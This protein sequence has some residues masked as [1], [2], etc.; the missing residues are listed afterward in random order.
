MKIYGDY[1]T[2][3]QIFIELILKENLSDGDA[4]KEALKPY[5]F[6]E[7]V[8]AENG[9][10]TTP[11]LLYVSMHPWKFSFCVEGGNA[12]L[13]QGTEQEAHLFFSAQYPIGS[14]FV[15]SKEKGHGESQ[16]ALKAPDW[17][18]E[19]YKQAIVPYREYLKK[20]P[21]YPKIAESLSKAEKEK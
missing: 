10:W 17:I 5:I 6:D 13:D 14:S 7:N 19:I 3:K 8:I 12:I 2:I 21:D 16:F 1:E 4:F 20:N 11:T 18:E 9:T 15:S